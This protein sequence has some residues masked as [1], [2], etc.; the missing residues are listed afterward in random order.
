MFLALQSPDVVEANRVCATWRADH[1]AAIG[2]FLL[3]CVLRSEIVFGFYPSLAGVIFAN[4]D[5][6]DPDRSYL[7]VVFV[8]NIT[9]ER[10]PEVTVTCLADIAVREVP[11]V[12]PLEKIAVPALFEAVGPG[13]CVVTRCKTLF[14]QDDAFVV[15]RAVDVV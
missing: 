4:A 9:D 8:V 12:V 1:E 11:L 13:R 7:T 2:V 15:I 10:I 3:G 6:V 14:I 5:T